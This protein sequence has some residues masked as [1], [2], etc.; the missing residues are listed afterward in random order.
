MATV[1]SISSADWGSRALQPGL[2]DSTLARWG[3]WPEWTQPDDIRTGDWTD[4]AISMAGALTETSWIA[5]W[6]PHTPIFMVLWSP[7]VYNLQH[8][9]VIH[10]PPAHLSLP[11]IEHGKK[12][13]W[14]GLLSKQQRH[15]DFILFFLLPTGDSVCVIWTFGEMSRREKVFLHLFADVCREKVPHD[16]GLYGTLVLARS[17]R[18]P[19]RVAALL[20]TVYCFLSHSELERTCPLGFWQRLQQAH[21]D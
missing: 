8:L 14:A 15:V 2:S 12:T 3:K 13:K 10:L 9:F 1:I 16:R 4:A 20:K 6:F 5:E 7:S 19:S 21:I 18:C 11:Y 17:Q